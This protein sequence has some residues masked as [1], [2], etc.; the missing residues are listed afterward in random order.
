MNPNN[1]KNVDA[2]KLQ[3]FL[4]KTSDDKWLKYKDAAAQQFNEKEKH[5]DI[6]QMIGV[7]QVIATRTLQRWLFVD[8]KMP[9][10]SLTEIHV[11]VVVPE[12]ENQLQAQNVHDL[13]R[14]REANISESRFAVLMDEMLDEKLD[15]K[16]ALLYHKTAK[17]YSN[18]TLGHREIARLE[19]D[20]LF[21]DFAP[22]KD[23]EAFWTEKI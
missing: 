16:L 8:N 2:C 14:M 20:E 22:V 17:S 5:P 1:L 13:V 4:A 9:Q 3:V 12:Q 15:E 7:E 10:P 23:G 19:K 21:F 18:S 11:L 6:Q